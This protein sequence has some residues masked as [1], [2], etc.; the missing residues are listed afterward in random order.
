MLTMIGTSARFNK[1]TGGKFR[2]GSFSRRL[3]EKRP[4]FV[5]GISL[6][7]GSLLGTCVLEPTRHY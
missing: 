4:S 3:L 5:G 6:E 7:G 2:L 1:R